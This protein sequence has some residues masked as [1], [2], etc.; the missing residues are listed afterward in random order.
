[1]AQKL[2]SLRG[3]HIAQLLYIKASL[4]EFPPLGQGGTAAL[5]RRPI[6]REK[7]VVKRGFKR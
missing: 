6:R 3:G 1:M 4:P 7:A 5:W 2:G